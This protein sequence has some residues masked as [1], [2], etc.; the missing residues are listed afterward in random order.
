MIPPS[1]LLLVTGWT[2][3]GTAHPDRTYLVDA[4][5]RTS[6]V[7]R[8]VRTLSIPAEVRTLVAPGR[9]A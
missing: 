1:L 6:V 3:P 8:D 5:S 9:P 7:R 2:N 4:E